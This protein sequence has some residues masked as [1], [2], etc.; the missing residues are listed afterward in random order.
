MIRIE[1]LKALDTQTLSSIRI[2][3]DASD[4]AQL[5]K[6]VRLN[7]QGH[8]YIQF[9]ANGSNKGANETGAKR[10]RSLLRAADKLGLGVVFAQPAVV[11]DELN[12]VLWGSQHSLVNIA[13]DQVEGLLG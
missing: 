2:S 10:V 5:P 9:R 8:A 12:I 6:S 3:A 4:L 7:A 11:S 13:R 1:A